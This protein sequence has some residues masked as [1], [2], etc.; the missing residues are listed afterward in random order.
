MRTAK[1]TLAL[2]VFWLVVVPPESWIDVLVGA[3]AAGLTVTWSQRFLWRHAQPYFS[4]VPVARI[5]RF[6]AV[7]ALRIVTAAT[8]VLTIVLNPRLP[9]A[10]E[11]LEETVAF[12]SEAARVTY[13]NAI[14]A[15]PGTLTVDVRGDTFVVHCLAPGLADDVTHGRLARDVKRLFGEAS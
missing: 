7:M 13:A 9:I 8:Q 3:V 11:L 10:P 6:A 12:E 1:T 14:T 4:T 5:P 2:L 15:T